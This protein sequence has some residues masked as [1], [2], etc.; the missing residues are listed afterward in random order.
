MYHV[1]RTTTARVPGGQG[2]RV[3]VGR[4]LHIRLI[5]PRLGGYLATPP[6]MLLLG[7]LYVPCSYSAVNG[8]PFCI[9]PCHA[10]MAGSSTINSRG[11]FQA[12]DG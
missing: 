4:E 11:T 8:N 10:E 1:I 9:P 12:R 5:I 2:H 7:D 3:A 6:S